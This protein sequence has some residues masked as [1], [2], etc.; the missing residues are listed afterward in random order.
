MCILGC[1]LYFLLWVTVIKGL[2]ATVLEGKC[3]TKQA[4]HQM[5][6]AGREDPGPGPASVHGARLRLGCPKHLPAEDL[7]PTMRENLS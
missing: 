4:A 6:P 3:A 7:E 5:H 1:K 2:K